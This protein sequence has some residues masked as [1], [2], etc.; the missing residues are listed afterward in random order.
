MYVLIYRGQLWSC[1]HKVIFILHMT[2]VGLL[3]FFLLLSSP[4][5]CKHLGS[6]KPWEKTT[7]LEKLSACKLTGEMS[8]DHLL[9]ILLNKVSSSDAIVFTFITKM[10]ILNESINTLQKQGLLFLL[11][12]IQLWNFGW[13]LFI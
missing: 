7:Y 12:Q 5:P 13:M 8:L 9:H 10:E 11:K 6:S 1:H 2:L 3:R 4:K